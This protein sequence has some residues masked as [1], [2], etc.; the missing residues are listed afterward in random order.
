MSG[1]MFHIGG[2][3]PWA[4]PNDVAD[5]LLEAGEGYLSEPLV[6]AITASS[7][8]AYLWTRAHGIRY[9]KLRGAPVMAP[10]RPNRRGPVWVRRGADVSVLKLYKS[11]VDAGGRYLSGVEAHTV[12]MSA[13]KLIGVVAREVESGHRVDFTC[14]AL[15]LAD[16]GFQANL[17]LLR[18]HAGI[19]RPENIIQRGAGTGAGTSLTIAL[20]LG[21]KLVNPQALYA[22]LLHRDATRIPDIGHYPMLDRLATASLLIGPDGRRFCD[23]RSGGIS[24]ANRIAR[25]ADPAS[26]WIVFDRTLWETAG[27]VHIVPPNPNLL[28]AGARIESADNLS[29]LA[30]LM[31]VDSA[32]L[33]NAVQS[34]ATPLAPP[35]LA[36]PVGVG[37][38]FTMGGPLVDSHARVLGPTGPISGLYAVGGAAGG[39]QGGPR[40][41]YGAGIAA[42]ITLGLLAGEDAAAA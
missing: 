35:Y 21:A 8:R 28:L 17:D 6:R 9:V 39:F 25:M 33:S 37:L 26:T 38:T 14:R 19:S 2:S 40:P 23:E 32:A 3:P 31:G 41:A 1:A 18:Q 24:A 15:V 22:H 16:G 4:D 36:I 34:F 10:V 27:R 7:H 42:A 20:E 13:Q 5:K 29:E 11:F 12:Q 30:R